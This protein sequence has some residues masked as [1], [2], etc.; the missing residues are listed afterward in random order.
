MAEEKKRGDR[1]YYKD[2][3]RERVQGK[4]RDR[5]EESLTVSNY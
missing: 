3:K 5:E 2:R 1:S 4:E